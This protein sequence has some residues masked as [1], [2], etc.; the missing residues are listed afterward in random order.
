MRITCPTCETSYNLAEGS[1]KA[2][3]R[4]VRCA[5]C[6]TVWHARPDA[7]PPDELAAE[8]EWSAVEAEAAAEAAAGDDPTPDAEPSDDD[9]RAALSEPDKPKI[10]GGI[11]PFDDDSEQHPPSA[12]EGAADVGD[13]P[14][15]APAVPDTAP[16]F[17]AVVPVDAESAPEAGSRGVATIDAEPGGFTDRSRPAR[18]A[19]PR[20]E[21]ARGRWIGARLVTG[22]VVTLA[23]IAVVTFVAGAFLARDEV[24]RRVPD[25]AGLYEVAGLDVNLRGLVFSDV[26]SWREIDGASPVL[27]VEGSIENI[28]PVSRPVPRLRF[29]LRSQLGREVYAWTMDPAITTLDAGQSTRFKSLLPTPPDAASDVQVRFTDMKG[30]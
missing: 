14:D 5:R 19:R 26:R 25:L 7:P 8:Q 23:G 21:A 20:K 17:G 6:G 27:V 4:K 28:D 3:G 15:E 9:W 2:G 18:R 10:E 22:A 1:L 24:V 11:L 13:L 30:P 16:P 12:G 29:A